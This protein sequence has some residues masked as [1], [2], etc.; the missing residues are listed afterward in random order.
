MSA[1][2]LT[3]FGGRPL[4]SRLTCVGLALLHVA[5]ED[6]GLAVVVV[7]GEVRGLRVEGHEARIGRERRPVAVAL[8]RLLLGV[9]AGVGDLRL[10]ARRGDGRDRETGDQEPPPCH[11]ADPNRMRRAARKRAPS[12]DWLPSSDAD[13]TARSHRCPG[14]PA[15]S[16]SD[17]VRRLGG[18]GPRGVDPDHPR[19]AR[20]GDQLHRHRRRLLARRVGGDRRQGA[21]DQARPESSSRR[22]S[23]ARCTTRI[24]TGSE[25]RAAGSPRRSRTRSGACAPTTS[26]ST[27]STAPSSTPTSTRPSA[28][29]PTSSAPARSATSAPRPS[30][31][32]PWSRRSGSPSGAAASGS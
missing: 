4:V 20:R 7:A 24:R 18:A 14:K 31:P 9:Q 5:D 23:T 8:R 21:R 2:K 1:S 29:S 25:T 27:R 11:R 3:P 30:R 26:T 19:G 10:G 22:R 17:D 15:L 32:R 16:R 13:T 12:G 6:V 28:P